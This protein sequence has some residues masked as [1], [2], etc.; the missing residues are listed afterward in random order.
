MIVKNMQ[1]K[2]FEFLLIT[3]KQNIQ[4]FVEM[5]LNVQVLMYIIIKCMMLYVLKEAFSFLQT[6][7]LCSSF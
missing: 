1:E 3:K 5:F 6:L 4:R 2:Q 7:F